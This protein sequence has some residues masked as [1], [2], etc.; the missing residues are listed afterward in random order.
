ME[1]I[2]THMIDGDTTGLKTALLYNKE[3]LDS[4]VKKDRRAI[5]AFFN[6]EEN[7]VSPVVSSIYDQYLKLNMQEG[8]VESYN[9]IIGW[10][11]AYQKKYGKI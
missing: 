9:E 8:G 6:K 1:E 10:L 3:H 7:K 2:H 4:L 5:R 11:L